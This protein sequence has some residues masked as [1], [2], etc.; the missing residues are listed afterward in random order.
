MEQWA[1]SIAGWFQANMELDEDKTEVIEYSL[2]SLF[3]LL[4]TLLLII[5]IC[6]ILGVL[7][8]GLTAA[9]TMAILRSVTGGAHLGSPWR[10][11]IVST[12]LPAGFGY[13][14]RHFASFIPERAMLCFLIILLIWGLYYIIRYAPV[15]S[16][17]KPIRPERRFIYRRLGIG[18]AIVWAVLAFVLLYFKAN[19]IL[20]ASICAFAW[21]ILTLTPCGF[22]IYNQ[23]SQ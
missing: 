17:A 13:L 4:F 2:I 22:Q 10:C 11:V 7:R 19:G 5:A 3:L 6:W 9:L 20:L 14:S 18:I 21:Q 16:E 8:E 12:I 15:E 1:K 23:L